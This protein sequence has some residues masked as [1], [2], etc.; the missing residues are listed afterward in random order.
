MSGGSLDYVYSRLNDAVIEIKR[1]ATTPL[2]KAFAEH[3]NDVSMALYDLEMLY[4]G[5]FSDGDE[6]ESLMKVVSKDLVLDTIV[7]DAEVILVDLQN[8]LIDVKSLY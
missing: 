2:Q 7:K 6:I 3:L 8:A 1:R 5:D 4:S